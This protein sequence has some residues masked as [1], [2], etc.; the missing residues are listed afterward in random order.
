MY[1]AIEI[2]FVEVKAED[3]SLFI[4]EVISASNCTFEYQIQANGSDLALNASSSESILNILEDI[5]DG[6]IY[7]IINNMDS[8]GLNLSKLD[9]QILKY[10]GSFDL[11]ILCE[12]DIL[13]G[14]RSIRYIKEWANVIATKLKAKTYYCGYEPAYDESTRFFTENILGPIK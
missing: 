9:F 1:N 4:K 10:S 7:F 2:S 13:F 6:A 3:L 8:Y 11:N 12:R 14:E 5:S